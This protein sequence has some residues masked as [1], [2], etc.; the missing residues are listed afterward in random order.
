MD[1]ENGTLTE[2][3]KHQELVDHLLMKLRLVK[4]ACTPGIQRFIPSGD[5]TWQT[6]LTVGVGEDGRP[7]VTKNSFRLYTH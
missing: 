3:S 2:R 6:E 7:L 1:S 5:P 4:F